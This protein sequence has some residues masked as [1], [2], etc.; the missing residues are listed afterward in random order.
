MASPRI[1][2]PIAIHTRAGKKLTGCQLYI[3]TLPAP[4][5]AYG[6]P[7]ATIEPSADKDTD[8]PAFPAFS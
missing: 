3:F 2:S 1:A 8:V 4:S 5:A 7:T 6:A